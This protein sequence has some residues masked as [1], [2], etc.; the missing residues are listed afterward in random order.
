MGSPRSTCARQ[1]RTDDGVDLYLSYQG[2]LEMNEA[3]VT[4]LM[5][6]GETSFADAYWCTHLRLE[7]GAEQYRWVNRTLFVGRGRA[8]DGIEYEVFRLA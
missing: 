1:I 7:S 8:N 6:G 4:A 5:S 2:S 3:L